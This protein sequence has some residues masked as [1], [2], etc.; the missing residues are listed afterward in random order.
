MSPVLGR[1]A[2]SGS[3]IAERQRHLRDAIGLPSVAGSPLERSTAIMGVFFR[4]HIC[5]ELLH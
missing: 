1:Y 2:T 4:E 5:F 3:A